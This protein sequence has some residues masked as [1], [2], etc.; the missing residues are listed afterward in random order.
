MKPDLIA[1][2][3]LET[4][5]LNPKKYDRIVEVGIVVNDSTG[6]VRFELGP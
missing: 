5:G 1:I 3:D 6:S 2:V 4:T